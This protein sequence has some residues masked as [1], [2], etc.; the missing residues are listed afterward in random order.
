MLGKVFSRLAAD[1]YHL[2]VNV[3]LIEGRT[4]RFVLSYWV[5]VTVVM[6]IATW[7]TVL[8]GVARRSEA[9]WAEVAWRVL[10]GVG[11]LGFGLLLY[12]ARG[13]GGFNGFLAATALA[14]VTAGIVVLPSFLILRLYDIGFAYGAAVEAMRLYESRNR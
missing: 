13:P 4:A 5:V 6:L 3:G 10:I 11:V 12:S 1:C 8:I 14:G 7:F 2:L 9:A